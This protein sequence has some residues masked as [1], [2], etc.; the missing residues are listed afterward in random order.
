[1]YL[2]KKLGLFKNF[3]AVNK[4]YYSYNKVSN[5]FIYTCIV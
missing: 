4:G 5:G 2:S 3:N 1:M